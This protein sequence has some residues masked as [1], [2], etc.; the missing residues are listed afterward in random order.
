MLR[1]DTIAQ[2]AENATLTSVSFRDQQLICLWSTGLLQAYSTAA[3]SIASDRTALRLQT[4]RQLLGFASTVDHLPDNQLQQSS[5]TLSGKDPKSGK[6]RRKPAME[7]ADVNNSASPAPFRPC[8]L[9]L[10][11]HSVAALR[12]STDLPTNGHQAS[13]LEAVIVDSL[14]GTVQSITSVKL[15]KSATADGAQNGS[16]TMQQGVLQ[17]QNSMGDLVLL[18]NDAV[19]SMSIK[20]SHIAVP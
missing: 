12:E 13:G 7:T 19:W 9:P 20:V 14:F 6:K 5:L 18:F 3:A 17:L 16:E 1:H 11:G 2:P 15:P 4:S 10:G 8:L